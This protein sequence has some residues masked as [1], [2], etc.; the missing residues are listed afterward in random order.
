[1]EKVFYLV[2]ATMMIPGL[3]KESRN[4]PSLSNNRYTGSSW[5][6]SRRLGSFIKN[7]FAPLSSYPYY[8]FEMRTHKRLVDIVNPT[9]QTV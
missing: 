6:I 4:Y 8:K 9:P 5:K 3:Y 2:L 1:K 7:R